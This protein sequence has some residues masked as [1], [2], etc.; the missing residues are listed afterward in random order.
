[1]S[2]GLYIHIPFCA[3]KCAYCNFDTTACERE[4]RDY[5]SVFRNYVK[6][7]KK[8]MGFYR[9][10]SVSSV[11]IGGGTPTLLGAGCILDILEASRDNFLIEDNA[12]ISI[13]S[14]PGTVDYKALETL[15]DAGI[16]RISIGVQSFDDKLLKIMGRIHTAQQAKQTFYNARKAGFNNINIDLIFAL[17]TQTFGRWEKTL[18]EASELGPDHISVYNLTIEEGTKFYDLLETKSIQSASNELEAQMY[19]YAIEYLEKKGWSHYEVA[20]FA[21]KGRRC[22][23]NLIYWSS[24]PYIGV[25]AGATSYINGVRYTNIKEPQLYI[26]RVNNNSDSILWVESSEKLLGRKKVAEE[27]IVGLRMREG[28]ALTEDIMVHFS[29]TIEDMV[30]ERLLEKSGP[31]IR[32]THNG[33]MIANCVYREFL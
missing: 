18:N 8:E 10:K 15:R 5:T 16:N 1:M 29:D 14:N 3:K 28:I 12:E 23:H 32:L 21:L 7:I 19:E 31:N 2:R 24:Q 20:N 30:K 6:S 25:G 27:V 17:P 33:L 13:E 26:D 22:L 9:G 11:Y 4:D